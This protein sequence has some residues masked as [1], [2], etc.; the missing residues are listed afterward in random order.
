[1]STPILALIPSGYKESKLYSQLPINGDGDLTF[2]RTTIANRVNEQGVIEEMAVNV[3]RLD[4]SDGGCPVFLREPQS[5]N[6]IIYSN[7]YTQ[8]IW[9]KVN[10]ATVTPNATTAPKIG[11]NA[12][13]IDLSSTDAYIS[14][15]I[16][17]NAVDNTYSLYL[18]S[19]SVNGTFTINWFD[20]THHREF[21]NVT[22]EWQRFELNFNPNATSGFVYLGDSRDFSPTLDQVYVWNAQLEQQL[23]ATSP[24]ETNGQTETRSADVATLD[25]TGLNLTS[26]TETFSDN[27]TNVITPVPTTYTVSQGRIKEIIAE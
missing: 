14:Y 21:A 19:A 26:I 18:K 9:N 11:Q 13:L 12:S 16:A 22:T 2:A 27:S 17:F 23:K 20:G 25:T 3:P 6:L 5:T 1:M 24:I 4:Y 8:S 7:D 10:G 15:P